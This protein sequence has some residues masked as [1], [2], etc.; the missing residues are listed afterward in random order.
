MDVHHRFAL[1][2]QIERLIDSRG[3]DE[4][5][6]DEVAAFGRTLSRSSRFEMEMRVEESGGSVSAQTPQ[7]GT[8]R[9]EDARQKSRE[10]HYGEHKERIGYYKLW[11][12]TQQNWICISH[13]WK[14]D[15][16]TQ[17]ETE[18][19][20]QWALALDNSGS[21]AWFAERAMRALWTL[22]LTKALVLTINREIYTEEWGSEEGKEHNGGIHIAL[23]VSR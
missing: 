7:H 17:S 12:E 4:N 3:H 10:I 9:I 19:P 1:N 5:A 20:R 14:S 21:P 23:V 16:G 11:R 22:R 2:A 18:L 15:A 13:Y 8:V 6:R